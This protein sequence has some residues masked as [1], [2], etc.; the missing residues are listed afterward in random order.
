MRMSCRAVAAC[1]VTLMAAVPAAAQSPHAGSYELT[2]IAGSALPMVVDSTDS[3]R[4]E[5]TAATLVL[6]EDWT[7]RIDVT[8]RES[9]G[10]EVEEDVETEEGTFAMQ[11]DT[12]MFA[13]EEDPEDDDDADEI[14]VDEL[15]SAMP[16]GDMLHVLVTEQ[17][18]ELVFRR[19]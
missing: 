1:V 16:M 5:V 15:V 3:C 14:E 17:N 7:Y 8:E 6:N 9:C 18:V 12:I 11:G 13:S 19:M 10:E 4:E 2:E